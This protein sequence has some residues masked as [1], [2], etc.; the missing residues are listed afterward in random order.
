MTRAKLARLI[1]TA[2]EA[3]PFQ[4]MQKAGARGIF[5][6]SGR[7]FADA[8]RFINRRAGPARA[9]SERKQTSRDKIVE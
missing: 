8:G 5:K 4:L 2:E 7:P 1:G 6:I 9:A 3:S